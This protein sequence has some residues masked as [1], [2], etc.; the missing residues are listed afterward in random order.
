MED[1]QGEQMVLSKKSQNCETTVREI[2]LPNYAKKV[3]ENRKK[4]RELF[5]KFLGERNTCIKY[6]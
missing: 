3:Q 4:K 5:K 2:T 6:K 1:G